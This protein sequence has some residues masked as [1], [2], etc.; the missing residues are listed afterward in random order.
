MGGPGP[1]V[2]RGW[3]LAAPLAS[4]PT[5]SFNPQSVPREESG[6]R[7]GPKPRRCIVGVQSTS[8]SA[9][10]PGS[11]PGPPQGLWEWV[12]GFSGTRP[13]SPAGQVGA[14]GSGDLPH[15]GRIRAAR[16]QGECPCA[17]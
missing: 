9:Q 10:G 14:G 16:G 11:P 8:G 7:P 2:Q 12:T 3:L 1:Q 6:R 13:F 4:P 15:A 5:Q 17:H